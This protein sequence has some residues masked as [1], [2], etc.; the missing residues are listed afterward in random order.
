MKITGE[1]GSYVKLYRYKVGNKL[2]RV[3]E[4]VI[5]LIGIT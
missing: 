2:K 1:N 3:N 4:Y 5:I